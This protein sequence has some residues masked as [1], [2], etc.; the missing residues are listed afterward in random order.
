MASL[1]VWSRY[2]FPYVLEP[3]RIRLGCAVN[4]AIMPQDAPLR[5]HARRDFPGEAGGGRG[6]TVN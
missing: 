4:G 5:G 2:V 3:D 1:R 6:T